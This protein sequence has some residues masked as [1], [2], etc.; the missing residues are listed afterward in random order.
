MGAAFFNGSRHCIYSGRP[1][2]FA[3]VLGEL[4]ARHAGCQA[5]GNSAAKA[6]RVRSRV[7]RRL[8]LLYA[9]VNSSA[10]RDREIPTAQAGGTWRK[11]PNRDAHE[12][13]AVGANRYAAIG[14]VH[15]QRRE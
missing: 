13:R 10:E 1:W 12:R 3:A 9:N 15:V 6:L 11:I 5:A 8:S 2:C 14:V 7:W 4:D